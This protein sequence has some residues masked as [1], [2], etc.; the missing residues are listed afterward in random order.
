MSIDKM[1]PK[2]LHNKILLIR[3][4]SGVEF[5]LKNSNDFVKINCPSC[6]NS[7]GVMQFYK[8]GYSHLKCKSCNTLYVSPR[9][10]QSMLF[11]YYENYEAPKAWNDILVQT[12]NERKYLQHIPRVR[13]LKEILID[14]NNEMKTFVDLGA[15]NGNFAK[16][17][18]EENVFKNVIASDISDSCIE[19]CKNQG[20]NAK[21]CSIE[22]FEDNL[23][24]S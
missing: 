14:S 2:E 21:K 17:V 1:R 11:D 23:I 13:K 22:D 9:P 18:L 4:K 8:Y 6:D 10:T 16:A 5:Y 12:N 19:T 3:E 20:L 7:N 24:C 15:G